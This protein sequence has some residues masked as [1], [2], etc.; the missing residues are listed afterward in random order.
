MS[1]LGFVFRVW[2]R[3][4]PCKIFDF[5]HRQVPVHAAHLG[6]A[7]ETSNSY[8]PLS[9]TRNMFSPMS[10]RG[11][12]KLPILLPSQ[13]TPLLCDSG[14]HLLK[15]QWLVLSN[16]KKGSLTFSSH[17]V[18]SIPILGGLSG[19]ALEGSAIGGH[20]WEMKCF[21]LSTVPEFDKK[22]I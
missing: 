14:G 20:N 11:L 1:D 5:Y 16:F 8:V 19:H 15:D 12:W 13:V 22:F 6:A 18:L 2:S 10:R 7:V 9:F 21:S 4:P 17:P 3:K